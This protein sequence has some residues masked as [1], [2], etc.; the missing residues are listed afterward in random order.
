MMATGVF[1][2]LFVI[3]GNILLTIVTKFTFVT[4]FQQTKHLQKTPF[5]YEY[6]CLFIFYVYFCIVCQLLGQIFG[7]VATI[8][9]NGSAFFLNHKHFSLS[10]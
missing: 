3:T 6:F 7:N 2:E 8:F 10:F 9:T 5:E 4:D 1:D